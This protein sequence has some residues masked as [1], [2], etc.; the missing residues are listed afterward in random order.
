MVNFSVIENTTYYQFNDEYNFEVE[1]HDDITLTLV[2]QLSSDSASTHKAYSAKL[3]NLPDDVLDVAY[4]WSFG[5]GNY[6][7]GPRAEHDY[8]FGEA[9]D[10]RVTA[11]FEMKGKTI[12]L[13][14]SIQTKVNPAI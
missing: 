1:V 8:I 11:I 2:S 9:F 13:T 5:D 3:E 7:C 4:Y 12:Q 6:D 10:V 14:E